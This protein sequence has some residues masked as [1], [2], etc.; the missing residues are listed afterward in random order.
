MIT[1]ETTPSE[2]NPVYNP[3]VFGLKQDDIGSSTERKSIVYEVIFINADNVQ[4]Y[5]GKNE[6]RPF[7]TSQIINIDVADDIKPYLYTSIPAL[8]GHLIPTYYEDKNIWGK[9]Q[10]EIYEKVT[11]LF[12]CTSTVTLV[13]KS[14]EYIVLNS[15]VSSNQDTYQTQNQNQILDNR[16]YKYAIA[17][18]AY[19]FL[20]VWGATPVTYTTDLGNSVTINTVAGAN[21]ITMSAYGANRDTIK[22]VNVFLHSV[23]GGTNYRI[24]FKENCD[25]VKLRNITFLNPLGGRT[26]ISCDEV[27]EIGINSSM[28]IVSKFKVPAGVV[29]SHVLTKTNQGGRSIYRKKSYKQ[30]KLSYTPMKDDPE[31]IDFLTSFLNSSGYLIQTT[32][33]GISQNVIQQKFIPENGGIIYNSDDEIEMIITGEIAEEIVTQTIDI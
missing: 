15:G 17:R 13:D 8:S 28:Q 21:I 10:I 25:P 11:D 31:T 22:W 32:N 16:P 9:I 6:I 1:I 33:V 27:K 19:D 5:L 26:L 7:S 30:L 12:S 3:I 24:Y 29:G 18:D 20:W 23:Y 2:M 4:F 14:A